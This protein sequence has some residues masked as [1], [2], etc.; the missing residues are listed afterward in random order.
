M[1]IP[2]RAFSIQSTTAVEVVIEN[3]T[4]INGYVWGAWPDH[5]GGAILCSSASM[6][7]IVN[8]V[9]RGNTAQAFGGALA[10]I[11]ETCVEIDN[12]V[13]EDNVASEGG[14]VYLG[15]I[16]QAHFRAC[17]FDENTTNYNGGGISCAAVHA[18]F[19]NCMFYKNHASRG[20]GGHFLGPDQQ[21]LLFSYC[22]IAE[23]ISATG[24]GLYFGNNPVATLDKCVVEG[25]VTVT[26]PGEGG[27][28][29]YC[30][31]SVTLWGCRVTGNQSESWGGGAM[32]EGNFY[33]SGSLIMGNTA[34][35]Y[36]DGYVTQS[37]TAHLCQC[38]VDTLCWGGDGSIIFE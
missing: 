20:G 23:N 2:R 21:E 6:P 19:M 1:F 12:C 36:D 4:V 9:F 26:E 25:N 24:G 7:R 10:C 37:G 15:A 14:A 33:A 5:N 29:L 27:G 18:D 8:C 30:A 35:R 38:G 32:I 22:S 17:S 13:F 34:D 28:G 11:E 3:L 16:P 31:G